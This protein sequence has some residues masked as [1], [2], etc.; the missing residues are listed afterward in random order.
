MFVRFPAGT[1]PRAA[2][3]AAQAPAKGFVA[4]KGAE[5]LPIGTIVDARAGRLALTSAASRIRGRTQTQRAEFFA[6]TFQI[7]QRRAARPTTDLVLRSTNFAKVCG[8]AAR[9]ASAA[10]QAAAARRSRRVV[11]RLRGNGKGRFRTIGRN[12]AA[13]VRG[14][15]WLTEERCD[16]TLTRVTRGIVSVR[17]TR[18]KKTVVVRAGRSYLAR[19]ARAAV[20]SRRP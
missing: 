19:A 20:K 11:T 3:R 12:S 6:G 14:T 4:L 10:V 1:R 2:A 15:I 13:T 5:V 7:R 9:G 18:L 17:D 16:G 8:S